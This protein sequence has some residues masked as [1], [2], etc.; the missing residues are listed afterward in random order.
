M[1]ILD[2]FPLWAAYVGLVIAAVAAAEIGFRAGVWL[3]DRNPGMGEVRMTSTVVG[4]MLG[5]MAF[6]TAFS[7][8]IVINQ[9]GERRAMV[10]TEANAVGTAWLRAGFLSESDSASACELLHRYVEIRLEAVDDVR[11]LPD[12]IT[13]SEEIHGE[14]WAIME[15]NVSQGKESAIMAD[16]AQSINE[17]IDVHSL[18]LATETLRLP[19]IVG[20]LLIVAMILSF[21]LVGLA[22]S[23]DRKR[24]TTAMVLFAMIFVSVLIVIADLDRPQEG[25]LT[26]SQNALSDLL[27]QIMPTGQ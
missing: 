22:S 12:V 21:L 26:V 24:D 20:I 23:V 18:R 8:G 1:A 17:V 14:L 3:Q 19:N 2:N 15:D 9:H 11:Q 25:L 6:L 5:L 13:R 7:L 10:V 27:R 4:G 16:I